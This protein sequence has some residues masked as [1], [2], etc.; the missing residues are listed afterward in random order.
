MSDAECHTVHQM[1][2]EITIKLLRR[3]R[4]FTMAQVADLHPEELKRPFRS[5]PRLELDLQPFFFAQGRKSVTVFKNPYTSI[6]EQLE[7]VAESKRLFKGIPLKFN[8]DAFPCVMR[9]LTLPPPD[10]TPYAKQL[11]LDFG[12]SSGKPSPN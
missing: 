12:P 3:C 7:I 11:P 6:A 1:K 8:E 5:P 2:S 9:V 4:V 10:E